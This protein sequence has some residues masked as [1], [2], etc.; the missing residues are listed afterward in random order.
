MKAALLVNGQLIPGSF[1]TQPA[2]AQDS[3]VKIIEGFAAVCHELLTDYDSTC[4]KL[5]DRDRVR[6]GLAVPGPFDYR[7][8]IALLKDVGKYESLYGCRSVTCSA[9][10]SGFWA[11]VKQISC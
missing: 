7:E 2:N 4:R 3:A 5:D 11:R 6:I 10:S 9:R 1:R 8:G